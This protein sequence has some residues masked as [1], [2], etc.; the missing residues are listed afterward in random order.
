[1]DTALEEE[2]ERLCA[3][4][5]KEAKNDDDVMEAPCFCIDVVGE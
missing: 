1:M 5:G 4:L 3:E 2:A